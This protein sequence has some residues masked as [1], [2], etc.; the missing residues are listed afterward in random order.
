MA[1]PIR[2]ERWGRRTHRLLPADVAERARF[3][4]D[5]CE[6]DSHGGYAGLC[7]LRSHLH[8][9]G[10]RNSRRRDYHCD[11]GGFRAKHLNYNQDTGA[12]R[13][14]NQKDL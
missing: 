10:A 3:H 12:E 1:R 14:L 11:I 7:D 13:D 4:R 6:L 8:L 2:A 5:R 9:G